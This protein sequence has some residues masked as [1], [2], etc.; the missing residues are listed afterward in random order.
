MIQ[1]RQGTVD[2]LHQVMLKLPEFRNPYS[3]DILT[4]RLQKNSL[5]LLAVDDQNEFVGF[6]CG[7]PSKLNPKNF[8]SWLGGVLPDFR[9]QGIALELLLTMENWCRDNHY[10]RL[11]FKTLNEHRGMLIFALRNGFEIVDV[12]T[13][14][15]DDRKRIILQKNLSK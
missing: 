14:E 5:I 2:E 1:V 12:R 6:K 3:L 8:Y 7:Y 13:S 11:E 10:K 9:R 15:K 4:G